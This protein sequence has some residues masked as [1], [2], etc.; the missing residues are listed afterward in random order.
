MNQTDPASPKTGDIQPRVTNSEHIRAL[1]AE[2]A[3][4]RPT[5]F[6]LAQQGLTEVPN[7]IREFEFLETLNL[8][9]NA[10]RQIPGWLQE[11]PRLKYLNL[12]RNPLESVPDIPGLKLDWEA[13]RRFSESLS[14]WNILGLDIS[15]GQDQRDKGAAVKYPW[16]LETLGQ[17]LTATPGTSYRT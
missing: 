15:T 12:V 11:L 5:E 1:I 16:R 9:H 3:S 10:I 2:A 13:Y 7:E 8:S 6:S 14:P 17:E 4:T